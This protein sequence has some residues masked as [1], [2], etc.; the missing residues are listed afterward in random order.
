M[1]ALNLLIFPAHREAVLP[2]YLLL[3]VAKALD[4]LAVFTV[5]RDGTAIWANA[6]MPSLQ[7]EPESR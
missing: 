4:L 2:I 7:A 6:L 1:L 3:E 5:S